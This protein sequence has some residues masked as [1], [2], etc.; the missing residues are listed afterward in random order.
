MDREPEY[1]VLDAQRDLDATFRRC[2][3]ELCF[4]AEC[5]GN[6]GLDRIEVAITRSMENLEFAIKRARDAYTAEIKG[7]LEDHERFAGDLLLK[8][9]D[10][11]TASPTD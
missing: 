11:A 3:D 9:L 4:L 1:R 7:E 10:K 6:I 2:R 8:L 5:A